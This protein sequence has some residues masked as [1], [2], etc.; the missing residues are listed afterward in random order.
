MLLKAKNKL[1]HWDIRTFDIDQVFW[2]MDEAAL[3]DTNF[4]QAIT[5]SLDEQGMLWPPIVWLQ[6]TFLVYFQEQPHRQDPTKDFEQPLKYRCAI[7]NNRFYYAK[8]NGYTKI[9]CV[10]VDKW[11]EKDIV[12]KTTQMEYCVDF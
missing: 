9:E 1:D 2:Q 7:G 6:E 10:Y 12:L 11:Q 4:R 8:D 5:K 3:R